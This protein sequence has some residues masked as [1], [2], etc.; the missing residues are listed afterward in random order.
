MTKKPE[1]TE[2]Q[3]ALQEAMKGVKRLA[4]T[5]KRIST[6][7][8]PVKPRPKAFSDENSVDLFQFSDYDRHPSVGSNELIEF[9]RSGL[10]HNMIRKMRAGQYEIEAK[11]DLHGMIV[12]EAREALARFIFECQRRGIRQVLIVHG[13]GRAHQD[14]ILKNKLN[15]WLRQTA[16]I[17]GFCSA[18]SKEGGTGALYVLLKRVL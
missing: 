10:Q 7:P 18:K 4:P 1:L 12:M 5:K 13:K 14:P 17:L 16:D 15:Q 9:F 3:A 8:A 6:S 11:L 2:D